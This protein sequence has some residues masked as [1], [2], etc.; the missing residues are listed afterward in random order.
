MIYLLPGNAIVERRIYYYSNQ[1]DGLALETHRV[2]WS[3]SAERNVCT[4][5]AEQLLPPY[6]HDA[7]VPIVT[8]RLS[9]CL[10]R[11]RRVYLNFTRRDGGGGGGEV[12]PA[13]E[14][15][16]GV[17]QMVEMA[18]RLNHHFISRIFINVDGLPHRVQI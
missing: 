14:Q 4:T 10:L 1:I 11:G 8:V 13:T 15:E 5:A 16:A 2:K 9:N 7:L 3:P 18:L 6:S 12:L 17:L